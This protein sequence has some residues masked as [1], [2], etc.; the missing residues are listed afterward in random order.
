MG[1][2]S[3][4][5]HDF[6]DKVCYNNKSIILLSHIHC[7]RTQDDSWM[8]VCS[9]GWGKDWISLVCRQL[10]YSR[11]SVTRSVGTDANGYWMKRA[12]LEITPELIQTFLDQNDEKCSVR[13]EV[14]IICE[15]FGNKI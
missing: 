12:E 7:Y 4:K 1:L 15:S 10:G 6:T 8:P 3:D 9:D 13:E 5:Q 14:Q 2:C 11:Q